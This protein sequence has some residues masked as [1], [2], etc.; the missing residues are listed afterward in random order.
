M[1]RVRIQNEP[2]LK[3]WDDVNLN[4][5]EIG[6]CEIAIET[7]EGDLNQKIQD[8]KLDAEMKAQPLR[9]RIEKL[10]L[11]IKIFVEENRSEIKGKTMPLSFGNVGFRQS[12]KI[13]FKN[14]KAVIASLRAKKMNDCIIVKESVDKDV[15]RGYPDDAIA[16][17]GATKK[18]EDTF[19]Y[20]VDRER[21]K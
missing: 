14:V 10:A 3:S 16:S 12:T 15:L 1:A 5:K 19:W 7:V 21:L 18:V 13:V 4:L 9:Q 11:E 20:E 6:E 2:V 8:L 17:I